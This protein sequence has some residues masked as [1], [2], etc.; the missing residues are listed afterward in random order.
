M[1]LAGIKGDVVDD[2]VML[3][4]FSG[5]KGFHVGL[6]TALWNAQPAAIFHSYAKHFATCLAGLAKVEIDTGVYDRVRLFRAPNSRH[7]KTGRHKRRL[8]ADE[9]FRMSAADILTHAD[10]PAN[11]VYPG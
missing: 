8:Y 3:L 4:F 1:D 10:T 7:Q 2:D 11:C 9:F 5:R 6:P